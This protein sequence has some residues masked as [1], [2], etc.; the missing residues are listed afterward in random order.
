VDAHAQIRSLN[1]ELAKKCKL[2]DDLKYKVQHFTSKRNA[3]EMGNDED[4]VE[5]LVNIVKEKERIIEE[6]TY[7]V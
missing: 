2:I 7:K 3:R 5:Y 6:L 4:V 1:V